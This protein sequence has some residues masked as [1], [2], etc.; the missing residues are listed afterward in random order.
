MSQS[1]RAQ[2]QVFA[3]KIVSFGLNILLLLHVLSFTLSTTMQY[4][5][6]LRDTALCH[7]M[8]ILYFPTYQSNCNRIN[9]ICVEVKYVSYKDIVSKCKLQQNSRIRMHDPQD[10]LHRQFGVHNT[11]YFITCTYQVENNKTVLSLEQ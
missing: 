1:F 6:C 4:L 10:Y 3:I 11:T 8:H 2:C 7:Y 5:R 9:I